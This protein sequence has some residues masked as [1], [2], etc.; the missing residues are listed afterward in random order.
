MAQNACTHIPESTQ[1]DIHRLIG[2]TGE[3]ADTTLQLISL[4]ENGEAAWWK[5]YNYIE[6]LGDGRGYTVTIFGACSGTGDL[7]MI[8]NELAKIKPGHALLKYR[9][10][11]KKCKGEDVKGIEGMLKD[12]P[13]L[14]DDQ[15]WQ[16]AVWK[17][18]LGMYWKFAADF[19]AKEGACASRPGP[20]LTCALAKGFLVD[21]AINHGADMPSFSKV[22]KRMNKASSEDQVDWL[23]DF[24][25]TRQ[26]M[27]KSGFE[28]LDTSKTGD[29]CKLWHGILKA[30]NTELARPIKAYNGYWGRNVVIA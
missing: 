21:T 11:L 26:K 1:Q 4:P 18:Y 25:K 6:K 23:E 3:Q 22:I 24:M 27:L 15:A 13:R 17:V 30:G 7:L 14:G 9:N 28:C 29:R 2:L 19:A 12:I 20:V 5:H 8:L 10:A 16:A